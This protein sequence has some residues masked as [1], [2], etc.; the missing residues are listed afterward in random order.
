MPLSSQ[1]LAAYSKASGHHANSP[2]FP[3]SPANLPRYACILGLGSVWERRWASRSR[4]YQRLFAP[5]SLCPGVTQPAFLFHCTKSLGNRICKAGKPN[6]ILILFW[7]ESGPSSLRSRN[8]G[9]YSVSSSNKMPQT[10]QTL[11]VLRM[12]GRTASL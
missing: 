11:C 10:F 6:A 9:L 2:G 4:E 8:K 1:I 5:P 3:S 12:G 7:S